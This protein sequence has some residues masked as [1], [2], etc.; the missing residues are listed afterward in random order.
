M[1]KTSKKS[2]FERMHEKCKAYFQP[3]G[4]LEISLVEIIAKE[5]IRCR[6]LG[7]QADVAEVTLDH[8]VLVFKKVQSLRTERSGSVPPGQVQ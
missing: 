4:E 7:Q 3:V 8:S 6:H 1:I 5:T 2:E